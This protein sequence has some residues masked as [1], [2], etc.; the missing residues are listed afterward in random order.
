MRPHPTT[1][2]GLAL[3]SM[4]LVGCGSAQSTPAVDPTAAI[5]TARAQETTDAFAG[6][7]KA[8]RDYYAEV[9]DY[10]NEEMPA[11]PY[12][13]RAFRDEHNQW[14]QAN[15]R[16][17]VTDRGTVRLESITPEQ[18]QGVPQWR[19]SMLVCATLSGGM[20]D[21]NGKNVN[22]DPQGK[23]VPEKPHRVQTRYHLDRVPEDGRWVITDGTVLGSC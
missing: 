10:A 16:D 12:A 20:Y 17:G 22:V 18:F 5:A 15:K 14:V 11:R 1:I 8:L 13:N 2:T 9:D 21:K 19:T 4:L 6:S 23:P 3:A 7:E